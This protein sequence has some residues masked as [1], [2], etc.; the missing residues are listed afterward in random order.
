MAI[1][2]LFH[3]I[4]M[5]G[6]LPALEAWYDDIFSVRRGFMDHS[7][8]PGLKRDASLLVLG[9]AVIEAMSPAF[10][11]EGWDTVPLGKF[12][13]RF[14][15]HW[16]SIAW[17]T[18]DASDLHRRCA[19]AGIRAFF[20]GPEAHGP[21]AHGNDAPPFPPMVTHP[22]DTFT[23]LE[24]M[25]ESA[26]EKLDP[27]LRPDWDPDWW[28]NNHPLG[29]RR[30]AYT[31][32]VTGD[33]A[34]AKRVYADVLGG[35]PLH[36][37]VSELTGTANSYIAMGDETIVELAT[38]VR[39]GTIAAADLAAWGNMHHAAAFA[40]AD[41]DRAASYLESSGIKVAERDERTL[42]T[43]PATTHGVPFRWT[44]WTVPGDP[45]G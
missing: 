31:T 15:A 7:Y 26:L 11:A 8:V 5:T 28:V 22:K 32:V 18:D 38:P 27:R 42:L 23:Q 17:Y 44:T 29:L 2:K 6:D 25:Q 14:G 33:L 12:Y 24:F 37:N 21:E 3:I 41:L 1:G 39:D 43:D 10:R 35:T 45:R 9:D 16:H 20:D 4:H 19:E 40:V 13:K 30:L 34:G 36:D